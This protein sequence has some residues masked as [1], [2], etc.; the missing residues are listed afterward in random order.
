MTAPAPLPEEVYA[1][2]AGNIDQAADQRL[3]Q[4]FS[5]AMAQGV[6]RVHLLFQS[7]GGFVGD[8]I[9]VYNFFHAL[10]IELTLYNA[11]AV[12]SIA[13]IAYLGAKKRKTS[14]YATF[15]IHRTVV[16]PQFASANRLKATTESLILDDKRTEAILREHVTF[17]A[18]KWKELDYHDVTFSAEDSVKAGIADEI[19][20][21]AP[22]AGTVVLNV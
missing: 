9:A 17:S 4:G 10:P 20:E 11:G 15:M 13:T 6:K 21:F 18:E 2:F 19:A 1:A 8:G 7:S 5:G 3:F 14:A 22:P 12:Q 16:S